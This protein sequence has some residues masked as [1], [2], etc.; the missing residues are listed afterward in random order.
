MAPPSDEESFGSESSNELTNLS[1]EA[2]DDHSQ[3]KNLPRSKSIKTK[4]PDSSAI[5]PTFRKRAQSIVFDMPAETKA[6]EN[7]AG[8]LGALFEEID[9]HQ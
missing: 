6:P 1:A 7:H 8:L 5:K 9:S 2:I 4:R 3:G